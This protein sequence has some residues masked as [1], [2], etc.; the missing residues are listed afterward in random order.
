MRA[1][2]LQRAKAE[3]RKFYE[4]S[5]QI[6]KDYD[7]RFVNYLPNRRRRLMDGGK[8]GDELRVTM[9]LD[10]SGAIVPANIFA[11]YTRRFLG[12]RN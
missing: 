12:S 10:I 8:F 7:G 2:D 4:N 1:Y 6:T 5:L 3:T 9:K 11:V